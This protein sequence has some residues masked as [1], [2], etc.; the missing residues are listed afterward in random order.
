MCRILTVCSV[1]AA[2]PGKEEVVVVRL[3]EAGEERLAACEEE[4]SSHILWRS[5][6]PGQL[7]TAPCP[8]GAAGQAARECREGGAGGWGVTMMGDCRSGWLSLVSQQYRAGTTI[9]S[10]TQHIINTFNRYRSSICCLVMFLRRE[11]AISNFAI[12]I[13][14]FRVFVVKLDK[15]PT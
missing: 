3:A 10:L 6:L 8:A 14:L 7:L 13:M 11:M 4:V 9:L 15:S 5:A 1:S 2:P 12:F